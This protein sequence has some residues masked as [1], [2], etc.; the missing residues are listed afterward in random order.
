[1]PYCGL[2][3]I[4]LLL[5]FM[6]ITAGLSMW[7]SNTAATVMVL[8]IVDAVFQELFKREETV[9]GNKDIAADDVEIAVSPSSE[10]DND[11]STVQQEYTRFI[12]A[13]IGNVLINNY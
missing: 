11:D 6:L 4:R 1:M 2:N 12:I 5:G 3:T 9:D 8:P 13:I 10:K 7:M